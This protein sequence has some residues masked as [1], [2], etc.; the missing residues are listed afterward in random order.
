MAVVDR[1]RAL[2]VGDH[3]TRSERG[4]TDVLPIGLVAVVVSPI[5]IA[6]LS[7]IGDAWYPVGDLGGLWF[8]VSQVGTSDTPLVGAET[9]KGF[10]HPGPLEFYLAAPLHWLFDGDP[11]SMMWTAAVINVAA[12]AGI[13][14]VSWRRGRWPLLFGSMVMV[15]ILIHTL[16]P[17]RLTTLWNPLLPLGA[18]LCFAFLAWDV[19]LGQRRSIVP[20]AL[21]A[22]FAAQTH[23][24]YLTLVGLV[25]AWFVLWSLLRPSI[26]P[27]AHAGAADDVGVLSARPLEPWVRPLGRGLAVAV[28]LSIPMVLDVLVGG[29]NPGKL[30]DS[31]RDPPPQVGLVDG[32]GLVGRYV[33]PDGPWIGGPE[34]RDV[35][36]VVGSGPG[37]VV[38]VVVLLVA[39]VAV[40]RRRGFVD[41]AALSTLVLVLV[42]GSMLAAGQIYLP[43]YDYLTQFL[44][45]VGALV[46]FTVAWTGWRL[47]AP[48]VLADRS[49]QR[50]SAGVAAVAIIGVTAWTW[51]AAVA[52]DTPTPIEEQAVQDLR[53]QWTDRLPTDLPILVEHRGDYWN[54]PGPGVIRWLIHDG[55]DVET[56][57]GGHGLKW[58]HEHR[59]EHG[60]PYEL[61]VT[62]AVQYDFTFTDSYQQCARD[63]E[64]E[65]VASIDR[66]NGAERTF[67]QETNLATLADPDSV[68][69]EDRARADRIASRGLRIGLFVGDHICAV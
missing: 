68:P 30:W 10:A 5:A 34:P 44:K 58:G 13:G 28:A 39:C 6:V 53:A 4:W 17:A 40:A 29:N 18:F 8:R 41:V 57:D 36:T 46:W 25:A 49:R 45:L 61:V 48:G 11:R 64:V 35:F 20:A 3:E 38:V 19:G 9:I 14:W 50:L 1:E 12:V 37:P 52:V 7:L 21:A 59:Y 63:P 26:V 15:A 2:E 43:A 65:P 16:D 51:P 55:Y 24:A 67:L 31:V 54:I 33:R 22:T 23:L 27:E 69:S 62:V 32:I 66:L 60:D 42:L 56:S 47:I